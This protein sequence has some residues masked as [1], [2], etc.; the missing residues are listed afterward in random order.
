MNYL[1]KQEKGFTLITIIFFL[2]IAGFLGLL[3]LK[4]VP[5]YIEHSKVV[6]SLA[7]IEETTDIKKKSRREVKSLLGKRFD[8]NYVY[9]L[10]PNSEEIKI[11][12]ASDYL[13]VQV[14]Y[15][16]VEKIMGNISV[17]VE[18]YEEFEVGDR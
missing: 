15:E 2:I 6:N 12:K 11:T 14:E 7:A 17:L 1:V 18:F 8:M 10:T 16:V 4:I 13:K 3:L 5:I 9:H